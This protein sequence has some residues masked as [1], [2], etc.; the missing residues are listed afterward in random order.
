MLYLELSKS[1]WTEEYSKL[2]KFQEIN[3]ICF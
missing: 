3:I 2:T 1:I